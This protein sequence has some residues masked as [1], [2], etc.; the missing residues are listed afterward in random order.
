MNEID[1]PNKS[2]EQSKEKKNFKELLERKERLEKRI[3][4]IKEYLNKL[5]EIKNRY[6]AIENLILKY[7]KQLRWN[8]E[9]LLSYDKILDNLKYFS[10]FISDCEFIIENNIKPY[11]K[12]IKDNNDIEKDL[13][14]FKFDYA[15]I[16]RKLDDIN[17]RFKDSYNLVQEAYKD[18]IR[19]MKLKSPEDYRARTDY[20][21]INK[22][23]INKLLIINSELRKLLNNLLYILDS[24][25]Y[26]GFLEPLIKDKE[27]EIKTCEIALSRIEFL[28]LHGSTE[29]KKLEEEETINLDLFFSQVGLQSPEKMLDQQK[30]GEIHKP[31]KQ[32]TQKSQ[33]LAKETSQKPAPSSSSQKENSTTLSSKET[34]KQ[35]KKDSELEKDYELTRKIKDRKLSIF[36]IITFISYAILL[37]LLFISKNI[38]ITLVIFI[39]LIII[40]GLISKK[41]LSW[42]VQGAIL[43]SIIMIVIYILFYTTFSYSI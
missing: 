1:L 2:E 25:V 20:T 4:D 35:L 39:I 18:F 30:P 26:R 36:P 3:A 33:L 37:Y 38:L 31:P 34:P 22:L 14:K 17:N 19:A 29:E 23:L 32:S 40:I 15:E 12:Y 28:I 9:N 10:T 42:I 24:R 5:Y 16:E 21:K 27:N 11:I 41:S 6:I 7:S 43:G 13:K 8:E